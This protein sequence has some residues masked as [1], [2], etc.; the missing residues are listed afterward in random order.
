MKIAVVS[1]GSF[2]TQYSDYHIMRDIIIGLLEKGHFINL[3]QKQ[4][5]DT[6]QYPQQFSKY[7]G[8]QLKVQNIRFKKKPKVDLRARYIADLYYYWQACHIM[9]KDCPRV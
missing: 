7:L 9:K 2:D 8:N 5:L 6:P 4:Y 3:I 1:T